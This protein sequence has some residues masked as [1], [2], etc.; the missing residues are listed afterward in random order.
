MNAFEI[1]SLYFDLSVSSRA[2]IKSKTGVG[3]GNKETNEQK[4]FTEPLHMTVLLFAGLLTPLAY[5][6]AELRFLRY[7]GTMPI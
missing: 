7:H 4:S 1:I 3:L 5:T 6:N 2:K